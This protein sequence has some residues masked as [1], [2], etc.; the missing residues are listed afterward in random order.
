MKKI[1]FSFL[2]LLFIRINV[3]QNAKVSWG[4][5]LFKPRK[6]D[7]SI[8]IGSDKNS[9]YCLRTISS[10]FSITDYAFEK[11]SKSTLTLEYI[12]QLRMPEING[13][14]L[15]F[16]KIFL[17]D[18]TLIVFA[19]RY[20]SDQDKFSAYVEKINAHDGLLISAPVEI[21]F[22]VSYKK[23]NRGSFNFI[24][25]NDSTKILIAH[26]EPYDKYLNEKFSYKLIDDKANTIWSAALELPYRDRY[27]TMSNYCVDNDGKVFMLASIKK[28]KSERER[29]KP[30]Y[31]YD[32]VSYDNK[33]KTLNEM[34]ITLG[35]KYISDISF[36]ITPKGNIVAGGFYSNKNADGLAGSFYLS[37]D[38]ETN[39]I[40]LQGTT[41]L[42]SEFL[43]EFMSERRANKHKELYNYK[44]DHLV[45]QND[46]G[47][48]MVAEQFYINVV[49]TCSP[50]GGCTTSY[51]YYYNDI[52][53]VNFNSDASVRW[54]KRIPKTQISTND[55]GYYSSY[56]FVMTKDKL[57]FIYNDHPKN[58]TGERKYP[59]NGVNRRMITVLS[60]LDSKGNLSKTLILPAK[61]ERI[62]TRPKISLQLGTNQSLFYAI[63]K[64]KF[65]FG[66]INYD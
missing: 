13:R 59:K 30:S 38:K 45:S 4:P 5:E 41:D 11:F 57:N 50:R 65:K 35:D 44:I 8:L 58:L 17:L 43:S 55:Y 62:Y 47:L 25:S 39:K 60:T 3:G 51:Y 10:F 15:Q 24:L 48:Y 66:I 26:N 37:I 53:V 29:N 21:D 14:K 54:I 61:D 6:T 19:S 16:E 36:V 7:I 40:L 42:T 23:R 2:C 20:D 34:Q 56:S 1:F 32:L 28:E 9:F 31:S 46:S 64:K 52:I 18:S 27:V 22:I 49:T 12:K 63:R 33:S